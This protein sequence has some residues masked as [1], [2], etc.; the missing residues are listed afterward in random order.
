MADVIAP[1]KTVTF[2]VTRKPSRPAER[3][4][5]E[6]LMRM[7]RHVQKGLE[8]ISKRRRR[9]DNI[10]RQRAGGQWTNRVKMTRLTRVE[11]GE[12]FTLTVTPQI[13]PD[14][15]AVEKYLEAKPAK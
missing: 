8:R 4:T 3:K 9:E 10:T 1:S 14:L 11:K 6:R 5:I 12:K 2:T 13:L 15:K 7:Q